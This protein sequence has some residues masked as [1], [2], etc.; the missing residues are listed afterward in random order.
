MITGFFCWGLGLGIR[1]AVPVDPLQWDCDLWGLMEGQGEQSSSRA[2]RN[3]S[4]DNNKGGWVST[5]SVNQIV[6][7][8]IVII[9]V[10][11]VA[12]MVRRDEWGLG[13]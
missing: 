2:I 4:S 11:I 5:G 9:I 3:S 6:V 1:I 7:I 13:V 8:V 10:I 12:I